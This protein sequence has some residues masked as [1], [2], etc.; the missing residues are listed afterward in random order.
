MFLY[1]LFGGMLVAAV[2]MNLLNRLPYFKKKW[3][4]DKN[5]IIVADQS[6]EF[7]KNGQVLEKIFFSDV[8]VIE[9]YKIDQMTVDLICCDIQLGVDEKARVWTCHEDI[10][11]FHVLMKA[12]E[13]LPGFNS[14]WPESVV[15]PA[16][17]EN[18]TLVFDRASGKDFRPVW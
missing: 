17:Q 15:K 11:G 4:A 5:A 12:F 9:I 13:Q 8:A 1:Y 6:F 18:R 3:D 16:F 10:E 7:T 2:A 14:R